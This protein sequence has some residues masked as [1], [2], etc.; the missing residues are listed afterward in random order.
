MKIGHFKIVNYQ[1]YF[2]KVFFFFYSKSQII[3]I[4]INLVKIIKIFQLNYLYKFSENYRYKQLELKLQR[5]NFFIQKMNLFGMSNPNFI[6]FY[7]KN[8]KLI[9]KQSSIDLDQT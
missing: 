3:Q 1:Y 5:V 7:T 6:T 9:I 8:Q 4:D 2:N